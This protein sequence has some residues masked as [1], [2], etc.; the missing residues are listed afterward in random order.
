M[1]D[2]NAQIT[3]W[4][5]IHGTQKLPASVASTCRF[6]D[7]AIKAEVQTLRLQNA[8]ATPG[9]CGFCGGPTPCLRD[10]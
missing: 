3:I 5:P 10:S 8:L 9:V 6:C 1:K 2:F 4:C 7:E